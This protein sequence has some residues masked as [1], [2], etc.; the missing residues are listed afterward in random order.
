MIGLEASHEGLFR[1]KIIAPNLVFHVSLITIK[2]FQLLQEFY[3]EMGISEEVAMDR[4]KRVLI[5]LKELFKEKNIPYLD[6]TMGELFNIF[7]AFF[8]N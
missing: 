2:T 8:L 6:G 4:W 5:P 3:A 1:D 7:I